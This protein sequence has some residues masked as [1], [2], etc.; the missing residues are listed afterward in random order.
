MA[1]AAS[2]GRPNNDRRHNGRRNKL[3]LTVTVIVL[4]GIASGVSL[5]ATGASGATGYRTAMVSTASVRQTLTVSGSADPVSRATADFQVAGNVSAVNVAVG[6]QVTAGQTLASLD[7]TTLAQTA[8]SAQ[9]ALTSAQ[10]K[11]SE[12]ES[13]QSSSSPSSSSTAGTPSTSGAAATTAAYLTAANGL[14]TLAEA[15]QAV[16]TAQQAVDADSATAATTLA[17]AQTACAITTTPATTPSSSTPSSSNSTT[18][19]TSTTP[20]TDPAACTTA[21]SQSLAAQQQVTTDQKAVAAAESTLAQV[22]A[23][24]S[25]SGSGGGSGP[26]GGG[27]GASAGGSGSTSGSGA[28]GGSGASAGGSGS[29]SGAGSSGSTGS[30]S[31]TGTGGSTGSGGSG[32]TGAG[33]SGTSGSGATATNSAEQLATDQAAI[34][35]ATASLIEAQQALANAHLTSPISGTVA[36]VTLATG[37]TV[38][39]G[40]STD[41]ITII[42]AGSYQAA[43]SLSSTQAP[44]VKV[45]DQATV[46]VDGVVGALAGTVSRVGPVDASGSNYTYPLIVSLAAGSHGIAAGSS[47]QVQVVLRE[48]DNALAVPTSAVH[49]SG[50]R[51]YVFVEQSGQEARKFVSV[52]VVGSTYTQVTSGVAKGTP[53]ILADLSQPVPASSTSS[54]IRGFGGGGFGGAGFV[55]GGFAGGGGGL[56]GGG[57]GGGFSKAAIGG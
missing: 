36:S 47:A 9:S 43:A 10:S 17:Q 39:A 3:T 25:A 14:P 46:T 30:T 52:G 48:A 37:Q 24:N 13:S 11:L 31:R 42:N 40:S 23:S 2:P 29:T 6:Q 19:P 56:A 41:A 57:G 8:S 28:S 1:D 26:S 12:D 34:D 20:T 7:S 16:V 21:L 38:T 27:S 50:T 32:G 55:G 4:A 45:G 35:T 49:T 22:L 54:S 53:V 44:Q 15:Q 5:W 33:G 18:A 51:S